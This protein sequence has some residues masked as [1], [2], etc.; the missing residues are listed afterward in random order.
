MLQALLF[1]VLEACNPNV[2]VDDFKEARLLPL[3]IETP[4]PMRYFNLIGGDYGIKE[5]NKNSI[6]IFPNE[7]N[8]YMEFYAEIGAE[9][10]SEAYTHPNKPNSRNY[11]YVKF[12]KYACFDLTPFTAFQFDLKAPVG[13]E[14]IFVLT[15]KAP[16]CTEFPTNTA[17]LIDSDYMPLSKYITPNNTKQTVTIPLKDFQK[18]LLGE[19]FDMK[20]L[21]DFTIVDIKP[22]S[23]MELSN[24]WLVG[25]CPS[26]TGNTGSVPNP[27]TGSN[28][29]GYIAK[30]GWVLGAAL[31]FL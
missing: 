10:T 11:W 6:Q 28:S 15:Q 18:N 30:L 1:S 25:D 22:A 26:N 8:G 27:P 9:D 23:P 4:P 24:F 21:K 2:L 13:A 19:D 31:F 7:T 20:H 17:R 3:D 12:D 5:E 16:N 14:M 29:E